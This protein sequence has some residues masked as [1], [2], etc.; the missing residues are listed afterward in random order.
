VVTYVYWE[1][2]VYKSYFFV[3]GHFRL[4]AHVLEYNVGYSLTDVVFPY[5]VLATRE[6]LSIAKFLPENQ[7]DLVVYG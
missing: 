1:G 5:E 2:W 4:H 3:C 7:W 6:L